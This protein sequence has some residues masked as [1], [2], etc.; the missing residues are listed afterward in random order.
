M[1]LSKLVERLYP[2]VFVGIT[3]SHT[4]LQAVVE[5]S[6]KGKIKER[7]SKSFESL[8]VEP[9]E[10]FLA[11]Y[12]A[13]SPL[14]YIAIL[15]NADDQGALPVCDTKEAAAFIDTSTAITLCQNRQWMLYAHKSGL[16]ALRKRFEPLEFDYI[17]SP[18]SVLEHFFADKIAEEEALYVLVEEDAV[19]VAVFFDGVL[20][21]GRRLGMLPEE[22]LSIAGAGDV[23]A[24]RLSFELDADGIEEGLELDD[25]N[26]IDDLDDLEDLREIE[27]LDA[28]A[29]LE[30]FTEQ[31]EIAVTSLEDESYDNDDSLQGFDKNYTRFHL[32]QRA[33]QHFYTEPKYDNRFVESVYVADGCGMGEDLKN[34]LEEELF[35]KV[36]V[37]K[38]DIPSEI[39][40]LAKSEMMYAS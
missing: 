18:F 21:Y 2:K 9:L 5:I 12:L 4:G 31:E 22:E 37:R 32:I 38:V 14:N 26:A 39:A 8:E 17:F 24:V 1:G 16:D 23:D 36:Y 40:D 29:D 11:P 30:S 19:S 10:T 33:L 28:A 13:E 15:G 34:Y 25:I 6:Q 27:D 35:M 3:T 7:R 20:V